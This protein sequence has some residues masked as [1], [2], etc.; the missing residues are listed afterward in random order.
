MKGK[1][2]FTLHDLPDFDRPRE[3]LKE[4]GASSLRKRELLAILLSNGVKGKNV[5]KLSDDVLKK[6]WREQT[7]KCFL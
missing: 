6:I 7:L 1:K 2:S 3:K 4:K 5:L